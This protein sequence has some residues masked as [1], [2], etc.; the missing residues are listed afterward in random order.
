M[1]TPIALSNLTSLHLSNLTTIGTDHFMP[2]SLVESQLATL[3]PPSADEG[4][5]VRVPLSIMMTPVAAVASFV[6]DRL[7]E[8]AQSS[9]PKNEFA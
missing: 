1:P 6:Y 3:E 4:A 5:L 7:A 9:E 8:M 2:A